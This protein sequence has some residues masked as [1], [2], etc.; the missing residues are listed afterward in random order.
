[1]EDQKNTGEFDDKIRKLKAEADRLEA[2]IEGLDSAM[3]ESMGRM[4]MRG[5]VGALVFIPF[6]GLVVYA[7]ARIALRK[8]SKP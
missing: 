8:S 6:L 4:A 3:N 2:L 1:M 5:L 7:A